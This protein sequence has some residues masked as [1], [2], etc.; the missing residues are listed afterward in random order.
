MHAI[1]IVVCYDELIM[2]RYC[3][4]TLLLK[5]A[6]KILKVWISFAQFEQSTDD[7]RRIE[8]VRQVYIKANNALQN[9]DKEERLMLLETWKSFEVDF[10]H[11]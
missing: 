1:S 5:C 7:E 10:V 11:N 9:G 3:I 6:I 8:N 2:L 4:I